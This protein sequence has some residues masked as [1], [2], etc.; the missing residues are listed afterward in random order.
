MLNFAGFLGVFYSKTNDS[1]LT[2]QNKHVLQLTQ[3]HSIY[4]YTTT[5]YHTAVSDG[6]HAQSVLLMYIKH[7]GMSSILHQD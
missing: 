1:K 3:V 4:F 7:N 6:V 2:K 5:K